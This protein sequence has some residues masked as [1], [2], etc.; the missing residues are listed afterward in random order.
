MRDGMF[1]HSTSMLE[2][3]TQQDANASLLQPYPGDPG[4]AD[5]PD[6]LKEVLVNGRL[7]NL[8]ILAVQYEVNLSSNKKKIYGAAIPNDTAVPI[9]GPFEPNA[10]WIVAPTPEQVWE[11]P[12]PVL[13]GKYGGKNGDG[14]KHGCAMVW[15]VEKDRIFYISFSPMNRGVP[16]HQM[17]QIAFGGK[18]SGSTYP[19]FTTHAYL[20][21]KFV[22]LWGTEKKHGPLRRKIHELVMNEDYSYYN[23]LL[24]GLSHGASLTQIVTW[25]MKQYLELL[26]TNRELPEWDKRA[27]PPRILGVAWNSYLWT[28]A[29]GAAKVEQ[30]VGDDLIN[31]VA[32]WRDKKTGNRYWDPIAKYGWGY[33]FAP[34]KSIRLLEVG[35][36][37]EEKKQH[38]ADKADCGR[39]F[40]CIAESEEHIGCPGLPPQSSAKGDPGKTKEGI[41][42][43]GLIMDL[44]RSPASQRGMKWAS[45]RACNSAYAE[46][47]THEHSEDTGVM[48]QERY[49]NPWAV[50]EVH[51]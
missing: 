13:L 36:Y 40:R 7:W 27:G 51:A 15:K 48:C 16:V 35:C 42:S 22:Q 45:R 38:S 29:E 24:G 32:S 49:K 19:D 2:A 1:D 14:G 34:M 47:S 26:Y 31:I 18:D 28:D 25:A 41:P 46:D 6:R 21:K 12:R 9:D 43:V 37:R 23:F 11:D 17:S 8:W 5:M 50:R 30:V 3:G 39:F 10:E 20:R 44:H 33:G 4:E